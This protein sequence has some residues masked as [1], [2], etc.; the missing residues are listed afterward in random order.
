MTVPAYADFEPYEI[1][2]ADFCQNW[3]PKMAKDSFLVG[4]NWSG[5]NAL[6]YDIESNK[7]QEYVEAV[8]EDGQ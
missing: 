6:G 3:I 2:L 1:S 8:M 4:V 7:V 5:K